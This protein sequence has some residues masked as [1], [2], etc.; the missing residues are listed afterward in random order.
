[1]SVSCRITSNVRQKT[2]LKTMRPKFDPKE[3]FLVSYYR[4]GSA[5][6]AGRNWIYDL[7]ALLVGTGLFALGM[8]GDRDPTWSIIGF[9]LVAY[10]V[11]HLALASGK[12]D[13]VFTSIIDKYESAI[14]DANDQCSDANRKAEQAVDPNRSS[15]PLL[16]SE[17]S[18][19]GSDD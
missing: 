5:S 16:K 8:F 17:S 11:V 3:E 10:R 7:V 9:G 19:R 13:G 2:A 4:S 14:D 1:M 6:G 15:A 12:Y 18:V